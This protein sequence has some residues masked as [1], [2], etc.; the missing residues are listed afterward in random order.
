MDWFSM[1]VGFVGF[2]VLTILL[3]FLV[4][5]GDADWDDKL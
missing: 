1:L 3:G 2:P 4:S 5:I